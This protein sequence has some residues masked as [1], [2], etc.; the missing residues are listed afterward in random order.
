MKTS[1]LDHN[2][3]RERFVIE[4]PGLIY[5][6]GNSLGRLP[7]ATVTHLQQVI[8]QQWGTE[9]IGGWN[10]H[11]LALAR[12]IGDKIGRLIGVETGET[13]VCDSTS[14][15][16]FKLAWAL[17]QD[18]GTRTTI[19]T[20]ATNF[21]TDIY[22]LDGISKL[23]DRP[24]QVRVIDLPVPNHREVFQALDR[25]IDSDTA[26]VSLSHVHFK[27]GYAFDVG[28]ITRLAHAKGAR[29]LW[30]VSH[31]VGAMPIALGEARVD[32]AVGCTYKY[33]NGGPGAPAFLMVRQDLQP[34]LHN[35]I[36]GWFGADRPFDFSTRYVPN[37]GIDRFTVGTP[38]ILS[39]SAIEPGV[40]LV[41]EA[42]ID[43]LRERSL[44]LSER[45][46]EWIDLRLEPLGF[47]LQTPRDPA[48]R[49]S[50]ISLAHPNAW[51]ITQDLIQ[52][53]KVIPDFREPSTIRFGI[54]PLYTVIGEIESAVDAL[55]TSVRDQSFRNHPPSRNGVT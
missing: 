18:C 20:D 47:S 45:F 32:A 49:G 3:Y 26:L 29:I 50:H 25:A 21:P 44:E 12:R 1:F 39:L 15:N 10:R 31:S 22:I 9:L 52:R 36:Q 11:W 42:G 13:V 27:S 48:M 34:L 5:L 35:P 14:V 43:S 19:I 53:F 16:M 23:C 51:Q 7:R 33:L 37:P 30:D 6:D 46:I 8:H 24:Y 28:A 38:P 41:L 2:P 4:D 17:L 40:D 54:T 55:E